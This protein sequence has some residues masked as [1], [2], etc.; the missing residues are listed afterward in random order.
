MAA[1]V[2]TLKSSEIMT[3]DKFLEGKKLSYQHHP[4]G[5]TDVYEVIERYWGK[6]KL[7]ARNK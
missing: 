2:H 6:D 4:N 7:Q 1:P 3:V 5:T